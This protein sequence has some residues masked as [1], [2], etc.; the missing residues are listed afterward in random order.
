[1]EK[2]ES[3]LLS[4][5]TIQKYAKYSVPKLRL[6][7]GMNFRKFIRDKDKD[8]PC[9][10]CG[11]WSAKD[12]GHYYSAGHCPELEFEENNVHGQCRKCNMFLSGNLI[13]YRK[14][15]LRKIGGDKIELLDLIAAAYKKIGYKHNRFFLI[16]TIE[17]YK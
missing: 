11:S 6:M 2:V 17:R 4:A 15:L 12:A 8:E 1:M 14:G 3:E 10:S 9:I 5:K 13:E 7:A 16:E